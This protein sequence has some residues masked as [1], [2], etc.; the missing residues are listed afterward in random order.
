MEHQSAVAYGNGFVNG[1]LGTD[2]SESGWGLLWDYILIHETGHEWFGN[3]ISV[4]DVADLWVHEGFTTYSEVLYVESRFGREAAD[5]YARGLRRNIENDIPVIGPYGVNA[6]GSG[7]MYFK[8]VQ[9]IHTY[10]AIL[11]DE[12]KFKE[13]LHEMGRRFGRRTITSYNVESLMQEYAGMDL[14]GFFNTY[15]RTV[16]VP[17]L[18]IGVTGQ[19]KNIRFRLRFTNV[20]PG[21]RIPLSLDYGG[22]AYR[23]MVGTEWTETEIPVQKGVPLTPDPNY[24][25]RCIN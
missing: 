25:L 16:K 19:G 11:N 2:L 14:T 18:R 24:Y 21:F 1:Y 6:E 22:K 23:M 4:K 9:L 13:L 8:G 15:L 3:Y 20:E 10:R 17:E 7:D 12:A 5:A